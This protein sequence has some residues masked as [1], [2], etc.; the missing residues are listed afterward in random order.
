MF[1]LEVISWERL[2]RLLRYPLNPFVLHR[3]PVWF[4]LIGWQQNGRRHCPFI[5][6]TSTN[7]AAG[8]S[9]SGFDFIS[10][11]RQAFPS[12]SPA[13]VPSQGTG[14]PQGV[15]S[16]QAVNQKNSL[17]SGT[18]S[19]S[20]YPSAS[21]TSFTSIDAGESAA[22]GTASMETVSEYLVQR[23]AF[24]FRIAKGDFSYIPPLSVTIVTQYP[25]IR[26]E[27]TGEFNYV[28]PRKNAIGSTIN[29]Q[30]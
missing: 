25:E 5:V 8:G 27:Y 12:G 24:E 3:M 14:L 15:S 7:T 29:I 9:Y 23:E 17:G 2:S 6:R 26:F 30:A 4:H 20:G 18:A 1:E 16:F 13:P 21:M 28:P 11:V 19:V 10:Q 22:P